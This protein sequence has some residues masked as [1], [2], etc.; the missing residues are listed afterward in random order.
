V[1]LAPLLA[2]VWSTSALAGWH[3]DAWNQ[4]RLT[5]QLRAVS[6][7]SGGAAVTGATPKSDAVVAELIHRVPGAAHGGDAGCRVQVVPLHTRRWTLELS[8]AC[9][10]L[11]ASAPLPAQ[12]TRDNGLRVFA[13]TVA[14][15]TLGYMAGSLI[16]M[17]LDRERCRLTD[18][19]LPP[20]TAI[21][22][23]LAALGGVAVG[24][25]VAPMGTR[26]QVGT[27]GVQATA[28]SGLVVLGLAD[29]DASPQ[30]RAAGLGLWLVGTPLAMAV[31]TG[32]VLRGV[33]LSAG[34]GS[35]RIS[36]QF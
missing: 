23:P 9:A 34:P 30:L 10:P 32:K 33:D 24:T 8:D 11:Q 18:C 13:A 15:E 6:S 20:S 31:R 27:R 7:A 19:A 26:R 16:G 4:L 14:G 29:A 2:L 28:L 21:A 12:P 25:A 36:G 17:Q 1:R 5:E 22:L 35:M 3:P